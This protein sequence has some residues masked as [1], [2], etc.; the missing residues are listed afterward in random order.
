MK[1][2]NNLL[3]ISIPANDLQLLFVHIRVRF[4]G[5]LSIIRENSLTFHI[6]REMRADASSLSPSRRTRL[7]DT[8]VEAN[9]FCISK[10]ETTGKCTAPGAAVSAILLALSDD[11]C[12]DARRNIRSI[13]K[14]RTSGIHGVGA[15]KLAPRENIH[16]FHFQVRVS[17]RRAG[18]DAGR[19]VGW[20]TL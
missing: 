9:S 3:V 1:V 16:A 6:S 14:S 10:C 8:V 15:T 20:S 2:L 13:T 4:N 12:G 18:D 17:R 5:K 7:I 11:S 19:S